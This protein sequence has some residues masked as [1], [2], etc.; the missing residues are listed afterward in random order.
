MPTKFFRVATSGPTIDGREITADQINQMAASY[1]PAKY[2]ARVWLEHYRGTL[3]DSPFKALGNVLAVEARDV[4]GGKRGLFAQIEPLPDLKAI[5]KAGQK[6]YTSIE[7]TMD[8]AK[9][10]AAYLSGLAVTDSPAS[11]GTEALKF[12]ARDDSNKLFSKAEETA[13]DLGDSAA[14]DDAE[15]K[16]L[17]QSLKAK[18][19]KLAGRQNAGEK[20]AT[21]VLDTLNDAGEAI[22]ALG[23]Q[24]QQYRQQ[25]ADLAKQL[26]DHVEAFAAFKQQ[27]DTTDSSTVHR[28]T[29]TGKK[30]DAADC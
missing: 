8:F 15:T 22:E 20:F 11:I 9:T 28:H 3:P 24:V 12:T 27:M 18:F 14:A 21:D 25:N 10:G 26:K 7:I 19:A 6:I 16:G 5:N 17:I 13:I 2:G 29:A 4:E 23:E 30:A 1:D